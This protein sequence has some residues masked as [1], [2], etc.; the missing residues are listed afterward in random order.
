M[1]YPSVRHAWESLVR[2]AGLLWNPFQACGG[3]FLADSQV[4]LFYPLN[5]VFYLLDREAAM[6][7]SVLLNLVVAGVGTLLLARTVGLGLTGAL[8]AAIAFQLGGLTGHLASWSP[9]H[10]GTW[11]WMPVALWATER[12]VERPSARRAIG[13]GVVLTVQMLPG[14]LP[15]LFFTGQV[16]ALRVLWALATRESTRPLALLGAAAAGLVLPALLG[17]AQLLPAVELARASVRTRPLPAWQVGQGP[18]TFGGIGSLPDGYLVVGMGA[19][20]LVA[21]ARPD[22]R[23]HVLF[24]ALVA[25]GYLVLSLGPGTPLFDLYARL[26]FGTAFRFSDRLRWVTSFALAVLVGFGAEAVTRGRGLRIALPALV[27]ANALWVGRAPLFGLRRGD[28]Y[29]THA[30]AFAFVRER[31]TPQDRVAIVGRFTDFGLSAK[32]ATLFRVPAIY[33]YQAQ[34]SARYADFFTFMRLGRPL[35]DVGEWYWIYG[36]MLPPTV[37]RPLFDLTAARYLMVD[38]A[39]DTVSRALPTGV[40][41]LAEI[42]GVRVYENLQALSRARFVP[43]VAVVADEAVLET[44][45]SPAHDARRVALVERTPAGGTGEPSAG[46]TVTILTDEPERVAVRVTATAPGFLVLADQHAAGWAVAVNGTPQ[47]LERADYV[48]RLVAVPAGTSEVV[49]RYRPWAV[50][51]GAGVSAVAVLI[52]L[53]VSWRSRTRRRPSER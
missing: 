32:S 38:P 52:V 23:R 40:R 8:S 20:A 28:V 36:K 41:L 16:V 51:A 7:A 1:F 45:A 30:A 14:Y 17:A 39:L 26:P 10:L 44:L 21:V 33:D 15:L 5:V 50:G 12:L 13:L 24:Y 37:R 35:Q 9:I 4:G 46:G 43:A 11:V 6:Q 27:L 49:F 48:F 47:P 19:L 42:G 34:G 2:G 53:V 25:V 22:R 18:N 31:L 3:P 29:G